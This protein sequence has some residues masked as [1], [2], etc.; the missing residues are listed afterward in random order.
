MEKNVGTLDKAIRILIALVIAIVGYYYQSWWGLIA[1]VPLF[2]VF[3]GYC[4]AYSPF[5]IS[6]KKKKG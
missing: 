5:K 1:I 6:T 3:C 2:T 4:P